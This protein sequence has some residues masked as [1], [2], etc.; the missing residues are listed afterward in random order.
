MCEKLAFC[1]LLIRFQGRIED[2]LKVEGGGGGGGG[3]VR[4]GLGHGLC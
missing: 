1:L 3:S 4:V 2:Q